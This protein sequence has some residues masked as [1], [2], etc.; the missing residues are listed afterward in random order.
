[1]LHVLNGTLADNLSVAG[2]SESEMA[3]SGHGEDY[4]GS[5]C[6][7]QSRTFSPLNF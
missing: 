6:R 5:L 1:M 3:G 4:R 2:S 7:A